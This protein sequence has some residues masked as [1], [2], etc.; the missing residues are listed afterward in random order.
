[1]HVPRS[2]NTAATWGDGDPVIPREVQAAHDAAVALG[3]LTYADPHTGRPV[4][5]RLRL[6]DQ[7]HC[8]GLGCR[9]C[10][11]PAPQQAQAGRG[12]LRPPLPSAGARR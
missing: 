6:L 10:P 9:H 8:C 4:T 5:T 11:W 1:M 3:M 2:P 12:Q 7:G